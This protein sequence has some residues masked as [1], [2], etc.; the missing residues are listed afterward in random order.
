MTRRL[1]LSF[2]SAS[3][4]IEIPHRR[5]QLLSFALYARVAGLSASLSAR[6]LHRLCVL[7]VACAAQ[8]RARVRARSAAP[9]WECERSLLLKKNDGELERTPLLARLSLAALSLG[10]DHPRRCPCG[11]PRGAPRG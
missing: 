8:Q 9:D 6:P 2:F 4:R 1:F 7:T 3:A 10:T 5:A 11:A